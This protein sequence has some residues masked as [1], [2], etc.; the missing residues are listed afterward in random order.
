M[1]PLPVSHDQHG[2]AVY[3]V[4]VQQGGL[5]ASVPGSNRRFTTYDEVTMVTADGASDYV[6]LTAGFEYDNAGALNMLARYT[7]GRTT[8]DWFGAADGGWNSRI[9]EDVGANWVEGTSDFDIPHRG[10]VA[11]AIRGPIGVRLGGI[12][13]L[14]SGLPFTPGF[15]PGVDANADGSAVNDPAFVDESLPGVSDLIGSNPC[16]RSSAGA[17]VKRNSCRGPMTHAID[18]SVSVPL[19]QTSDGEAAVTL[20]AFDVLE[21][22]REIPDAA[23]YL[24]DP[25]ANLVTDPESRTVTLPLVANPE[26]GE[27]RARRKSARRIRLGFSF[28]W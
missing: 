25:T 13:R 22:G 23:L 7:F 5:L 28:N 1:V 18:L 16:L 26:F 14:Q 3:G 27:T 21:S 6:G 15:R 19:F 11:V 4:L 8:D 12:Y 10:L 17:F 24:I 20:D 2:R 9:P